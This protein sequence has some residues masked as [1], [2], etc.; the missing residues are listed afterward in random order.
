MIEFNPV[1]PSYFFLFIIPVYLFG[2]YKYYKR[3]ENQEKLIKNILIFLKSSIFLLLLIIFIRPTFS[4]NK[5]IFRNK[6]ISIFLDNSKS[7]S[8]SHNIDDFRNK[9]NLAKKNLTSNNINF[10]IY[11]FGDSV[12][13]AKNLSE[14]DFM[15]KSTDLNKIP[16]SINSLNSDEYIIISDGMQNYNL[17]DFDVKNKNSIIN[18]FGVGVSMLEEDLAIDTIAI[19][20]V[21]EDSVYIKCKI[22]SKTIYE[23][24]NVPIILSNSKLSNKI[25]TYIDIPK[26][27]SIFFHNLGISKDQLSNNNIIYI[28]HLENEAYTNNNN[29]YL[30]VKSNNLNKKKI[31]LLSGRLSQNTKYIK[32]LIQQQPNL[33]LSHIYKFS[34]SPLK[35]FDYREYDLFIFDSFPIEDKNLIYIDKDNIFKYKSIA[36]FQGPSTLNDYK[37]YNEFLFNW[38]YTFSENNIINAKSNFLRS[39]ESIKNIVD[40]IV[41]I[42]NQK[43]VSNNRGQ[44]TVYN[45]EDN[46]IID[47][48]NDNLFVFIPNLTKISNETLE[49]YKNDNFNFLIES[50]LQKVIFGFDRLGANIYTDKDTYYINQDFNLYLEIDSNSVS[51]DQMNIYVY[52]RDGS[53]YSEIVDC[54]FLLDNLYQCNVKIDYS[55]DYF[56]DVRSNLDNKF[57]IIS[58]KIDLSINDLEIEIKNIG[59]NKEILENISLNYAGSYFNLDKFNDYIGSISS[60]RYFELEL[61]EIVIFNFQLFW[62]IILLFL[63]IEW[64]IRKNKGLL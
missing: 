59:L 49:I 42:N 54:D 33:D 31:L 8:Y 6:E 11:L 60:D 26:D 38:G 25:L 36:F 12:R 1:I 47:Y 16:I 13:Y 29:Y 39:D 57:N 52:N 9:I 28:K 21:T 61:K 14:I 3:I 50:L 10:K 22:S 27:N 18:I 35:D 32:T 34:D 7:M 23:H 55:G 20:N 5:T 53:I 51:Y 48:Y 4:N 30:R 62:F 63:I 43:N 24:N 41:P 56:I 19:E 44:S 45:N 2:I 64:M 15:D 46:T 40:K 58:N 17:I 37:V